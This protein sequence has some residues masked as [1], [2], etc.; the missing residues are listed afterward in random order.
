MKKRFSFVSMMTA[1]VIFGL[2]ACGG[3]AGQAPQGT[4]ATGPQSG[5]AAGQGAATEQDGA[6][7]Q[8]AAGS[9][10]TAADG[11]E[12]EKAGAGAAAEGAKDQAPAGETLYKWKLGSVDSTTNPNYKAFQHLG[13]LLN[14]KA[15]GRWEITIYPDSQLGDGGQQV[16][17][18]QMGNLELAAPNCS[19]VANYVPDYGV[20]DM[21]YL[22][23]NEEEVDKVLDGAIGEELAA[24]AESANMKMLGW[25]EVGFRCLANDKCAVDSPAD[26]KGL[27]IRVMSNEQHQAIWSSLGADPVPMSLSDAYVAN[28]NGTIDGQ[29]NPLH[30]L[31][32][33]STY[34]VCH[35][36]AVTNH[37][38]SPMCMIMSN[39]A[40]VSM[41]EEDQQIFMGCLKEAEAYQKELVRE[42]KAKAEQELKDKGC[43]I[44]YPDIQ[45]FADQ[46]QSVYDAYPQ[47]SDMVER[48]HEAVR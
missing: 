1:A 31:V 43:E 19:L 40:W 45:L 26:V 29:E 13:E 16:E 14:E 3:A 11:Q 39:K 10:G 28:Q 17:L 36:I 5:A 15:P 30:S 7:A 12:A 46:V 35:Y 21:P 18:V 22:F 41:T 27:R 42:Q 37:V 38:Y 4:T 34:E 44:S 9:Q 23:A 48:I 25:W 20:F 24:K 8:G 47:F 33:N 2:T 32:A 6:E